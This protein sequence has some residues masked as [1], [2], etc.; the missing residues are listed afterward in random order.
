MFIV[1][2]SGSPN[3]SQRII[4]LFGHTEFIETVSVKG[5]AKI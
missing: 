3:V 4:K 2:R 5:Y 1:W